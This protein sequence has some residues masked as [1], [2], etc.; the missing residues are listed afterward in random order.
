MRRLQMS[1]IKTWKLPRGAH[2]NRLIA[3]MVLPFMSLLEDCGV[4]V[5]AVLFSRSIEHLFPLI[6]AVLPRNFIMCLN[7]V[8]T[9]GVVFS[10]NRGYSVQ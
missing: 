7:S 6:C 5:C 9:E 8:Q 4:A 2:Q 1:W 3:M 10:T